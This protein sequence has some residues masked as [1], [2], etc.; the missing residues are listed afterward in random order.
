M[1][2]RRGAQAAPLKAPPSP[3]TAAMTCND[4]FKALVQASLD[5]YSA[6]VPGMLKADDPEYLHQMRVALRRM[7]SAFNTFDALLPARALT[8]PRAET[9][10]L[11]RA[12]GP[13]RDWDVFALETLPAVIARHRRRPGAS[14]IVRAAGRLRSAANR[15]ARATVSSSRGRQLTVYLAKW[16][17][18]ED[19][20]RGM[21]PAQRVR[22]VHPVTEYARSVLAAGHKRVLKRG[23]HFPD[24]GAP[25]L[26]RLRI[27]AKGL[28]YAAEFFAP[29]YDAQRTSRY[30][31]ALIGVQDALGGYNDAITV[32]RLAS[33]AA[34][35]L[36]G[37]A[38]GEAR[39]IMLGWS[40]AMR[41]AC[42]RRLKLSWK[43]FR[44]A[45]PFW[46]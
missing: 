17:S 36:K 21:Q 23:R 26:H 2:E 25:Q 22:L 15:Q 1:S 38:A 18:A 32:M 20:R 39:G 45:R 28:R 31:A 10:R 33:A 27:A 7:R 3:L 4:A 35:G 14:A 12:L 37:A 5:H 44:A 11:A 34:H 43:A 9:R 40:A 30:R 13:A 8:R 41:D 24:L 46:E 29:L 42:A 19:W 6:N 16:L